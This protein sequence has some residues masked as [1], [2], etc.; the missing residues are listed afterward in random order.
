MQV[1]KQFGNVDHMTVDVLNEVDL[2]RA[3]SRGSHSKRNSSTLPAVALKRGVSNDAGFGAQKLGL[4]A[5][6]S[7][8][9]TNFIDD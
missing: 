7:S 3:Y 9:K 4:R 8:K 2:A 1:A 5:E 6:G